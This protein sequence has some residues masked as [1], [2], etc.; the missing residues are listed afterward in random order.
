MRKT[1]SNGPSGDLGEFGGVPFPLCTN[2]IAR[3]QDV[4]RTAAEVQLFQN[5]F[6]PRP[7]HI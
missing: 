7:V 4:V 6:R 1:D 3:C 2:C 5:A